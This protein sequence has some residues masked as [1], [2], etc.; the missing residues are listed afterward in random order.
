MCMGLTSDTI[1]LMTYDLEVISLP[2]DLGFTSKNLILR[3][4]IAGQIANGR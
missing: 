3:S 4:T 2:A 1:T